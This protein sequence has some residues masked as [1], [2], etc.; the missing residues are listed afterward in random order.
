MAKAIRWGLWQHLSP[1]AGRGS[2]PGPHSDTP[3]IG[4]YRVPGSQQTAA[5]GNGGGT[6]GREAGPAP[7]EGSGGPG[8]RHGAGAGA[9]AA[10]GAVEAARPLV[11]GRGGAATPR[12]DASEPAR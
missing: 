9:D 4:Y 8:G 2:P 11:A 5:R 10:G 3:D 6:L 1:D 12:R 7:G